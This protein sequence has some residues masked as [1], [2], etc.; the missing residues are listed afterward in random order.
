MARKESVTMED[1]LSNAFEM[2]R[3]EGLENVTTRRIADRV[4]CS[5][6]PIYRVYKNMEELVAAIY[7]R[8]IAFYNDFVDNCAPVDQTPFVNMGMAYIRFAEAEKNLF[9]ML[10]MTQEHGGKTLYELLNGDKNHVMIEITKAKEMG[11]NNPSGIFME[12]WIMIHGIAG[13]TITGDY[14]LP[15]EETVAL[16]KNS[17]QSFLGYGS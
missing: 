13:M 15:F 11:A 2:A 12:M 17:Y 9:R 3:E 1:I 4:G 10:F 5:T 8:A 16:L 7:E 14:D 6:Q